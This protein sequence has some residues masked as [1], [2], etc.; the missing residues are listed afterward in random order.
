MF[1]LKKNPSSPL[2][3]DCTTALDAFAQL[4]DIVLV[5]VR[6]SDEWV[7]GHAE[8]SINIPLEELAERLTELPTT[9]R[10]VCICR[11]GRRSREGTKR[12]RRANL[13]AANLTGGMAAWVPR[14]G[15]CSSAECGATTWVGFAAS[16]TGPASARRYRR[17]R[18]IA[19][20][21]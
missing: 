8:G 16:V 13:N 15:F 1:K 21:C 3:S 20:F 10:I 4:G 12:L 14:A 5:D 17:P 19:R 2:D 11:S 18:D 7:A 9:S 6:S